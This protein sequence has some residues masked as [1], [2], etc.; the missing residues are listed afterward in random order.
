VSR[1]LKEVPQLARL[2]LSS[3]DAAEIDPE[4][5]DVFAGAARLMPTCTSRFSPGRSHPQA[6]EAAPPARRRHRTGEKKSARF[7]P[8]PPSAPTSSP[9]SRP[10]ARRR[11]ENTL[12]LVERRGFA[13]VHVFPFS[14][15]P[16]VPAA[17][18]PPVAERR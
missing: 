10:R 1:I 5:K 17:R 8:T 12:A 4:L 14:A 3:L 9:A 16:G 18:M 13:F 7:A 6:D 15:R 2:R 11:S